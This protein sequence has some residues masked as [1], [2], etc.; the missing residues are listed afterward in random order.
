M[1][2]CFSMPGIKRCSSVHRVGRAASSHTMWRLMDATRIRSV[3]KVY[4]ERRFLFSQITGNIRKFQKKIPSIPFRLIAHFRFAAL[5]VFNHTACRFAQK[6]RF[7]RSMPAGQRC[8][9]ASRSACF[10]GKAL[11]GAGL[12]IPSRFKKEQAWTRRF[13]MS[14]PFYLSSSQLDAIRP[15]LP[16][17]RGRP[18]VDAQS[19]LG[20]II[21][22]LRSGLQ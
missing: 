16:C 22:G 12:S 5:C 18:R 19:V 10:N 8:P 1:P 6:P 21:H 14:A 3:S 9:A 2:C 7:F 15:F 4:G 13:F 11:Q 20:G 17:S